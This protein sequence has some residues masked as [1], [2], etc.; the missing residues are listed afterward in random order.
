MVGLAIF[1]FCHL[2]DVG[3]TNPPCMLRVV[4]RFT[5][6]ADGKITQQ[7]NHYDP[8]LTLPPSSQE[9]NTATRR[10]AAQHVGDGGEYRCHIL[11][12]HDLPPCF[13]LLCRGA[14]RLDVL[15][16]PEQIGG[17]VGVFQ[18]HQPLVLL[19]AVGGLEPFGTLV[20]FRT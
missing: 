12:R 2:S 3:I 7:E 14:R 5:V 18:R 13:G 8:R 1:V 19:R 20:S 6:N 17:I 15:V 11:L 10:G 16:E 4:D 9:E